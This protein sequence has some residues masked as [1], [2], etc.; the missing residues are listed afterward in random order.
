[1]PL[2]K[3]DFI[4]EKARQNRSDPKGEKIL[5][6][7]HAI[8]ELAEESW[9]RREVE[10]ALQSSE[11]VEDYPSQHR[12]LPDCLVLGWMSSRKP[13]HAVVA[14]DETHD[15]LFVVTVY[16]PSLEEWEDGWRT[17]KS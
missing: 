9:S 10:E 5:W 16:Q 15:R 14:I 2:I 12:F 7:R 8:A 11:I 4:C 3:Q 17:R 1:M 6:S 13:V